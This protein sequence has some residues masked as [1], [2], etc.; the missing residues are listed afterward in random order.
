M[1]LDK[2]V[3]QLKKDA[4]GN[5]K[6]AALLGVMA[7]VAL[8]FWAPLVWRWVKPSSDRAQLATN[9]VALILTD[10]PADASDKGRGLPAN[11]FRWDR[12]R[13]LIERDSRM[14]SATFEAGWIDPF[15]RTEILQPPEP[16]AAASKPET[17]QEV[18][19]QEA[20]LELTSLVISPRVRTATI[21]GET[22]AEK[23]VVSAAAK[24]GPQGVDFRIERIGRR[25]VELVREGKTYLLELNKPGLAQGDEIERT[26]K[27]RGR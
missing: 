13:Q 18:T 16:I 26:K 22:Y 15:A 19:P 7:L 12:V 9:N 10:D 5:P 23:E 25:G 17:I 24:D 20:G 3:K 1:K 27:Q 8:Y 4:A 6:K 14:T 11:R 21:N 2:L